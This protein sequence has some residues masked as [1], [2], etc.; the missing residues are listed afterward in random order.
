MRITTNKLKSLR[1]KSGLSQNEIANKLGITQSTYS[2]WESGKVRIDSN[3]LKKLSEIFGVSIDYLLENDKNTLNGNPL[4]ENI[5]TI[6][7][8]GGER[9]DYRLSEENAKLLEQLAEKMSKE[10]IDGDF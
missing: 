10:K 4:Q 3:S 2:Y 5:V 9:R 6:F 7:G 8:Y 1:K